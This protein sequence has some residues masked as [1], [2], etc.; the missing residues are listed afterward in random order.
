MR[1]A[2]D[3]YVSDTVRQIGK[4]KAQVLRT[5]KTYDI[6]DQPCSEIR[7]QDIV[8]FAKQLGARMKPQTVGNYLSHLGAVFAIARPAWGYELD[9]QA[10][11]AYVVAKSLGTTKKG[12]SRERRA[13]IE[14]MNQIM[15]HFAEKSR[16]DPG[17]FPMC[18]IVGFALFST[19]RQEE[20]TRARRAIGNGSMTAPAERKT[21]KRN[22]VGSLRVLSRRSCVGRAKC[23][24]ARLSPS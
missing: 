13:T 4:T 10:K 16:I 2:I 20:I 5:I 21:Q 18:A 11:D 17:C 6:A 1:E 24:I 14:E 15:Q 22:R 3:R 19:R 12:D 9:Q 8:A 7:S 23:Q